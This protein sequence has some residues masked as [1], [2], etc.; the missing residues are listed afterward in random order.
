MG[1]WPKFDESYF[2]VSQRGG[3]PYQESGLRGYN[4]RQTIKE[5]KT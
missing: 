5:N 3:W 2:G 4:H 1:K